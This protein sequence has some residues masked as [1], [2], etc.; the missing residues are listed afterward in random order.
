M[1]YFGLIWLA[2]V[3]V[4]FVSNAQ[5]DYNLELQ[6]AADQISQKIIGAGKKSVAVLD[7][8]NSNS[9]ISELGRWLANVF[10]THLENAS[11]GQFSVKNRTDIEK[12]IQQIKSETGSGAFDSK[13][14]QRL[15]EISGSDVIAYGEITLM[16]NEITVNIR[17]KNISLNSVIGGVLISFTATDG[18]RTK[19]DNFLET[20]TASPSSNPVSAGIGSSFEGTARTSKDSNCKEKNT[21][22]YCFQNNTKVSLIVKLVVRGGGA[23]STLQECSLQPGQK[24]CFYDLQSRSWSYM[25]FTTRAGTNYQTEYSSGSMYVEACKEKTFIIK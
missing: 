23:Y 2:F 6:K 10:T 9:Q 16:D 14:I 8:E 4:S 25:I 7:F 15:G 19:Y 20:T 24:Q 13:T 18:M 21:G 5:S 12:S 22:D 11:N 3:S 1:R 17:T